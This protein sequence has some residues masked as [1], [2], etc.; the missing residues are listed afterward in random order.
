MRHISIDPACAGC[1]IAIWEDTTL[2]SAFYRTGTPEEIVTGLALADGVSIECPMFYGSKTS[3]DIDPND[4]ITLAVHVG[5]L[6]A[7]FEACGASVNLVLP[8]EWKRQISKENTKR[9]AKRELTEEEL[10][11]V[12][13][14]RGEKVQT[15]VWDAVGIGLVVLRRLR[16]GLV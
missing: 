5:G 8:P 16:P 13:L 14:P 10:G 15:D 12:K 6:K 11:A 1:G 4:L 7:L 2:V 9:R 3:K